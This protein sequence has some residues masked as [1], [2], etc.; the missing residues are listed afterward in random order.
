MTYSV[1]SRASATPDSRSRDSAASWLPCVQPRSDSQQRLHQVA[2]DPPAVRLEGRHA[3]RKE[4]RGQRA[5]VP[6]MLGWVH[7]VGYSTVPGYAAVGFGVGQDLGDVRMAKQRP[8]EKLTVGDGAALSH[9]II[10]VTL[11]AQDGDG[12]RVPIG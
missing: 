4:I 7:A 12:T 5:T 8:V 2:R 10:R 11:I 3:F 9:L 6:G 1:N